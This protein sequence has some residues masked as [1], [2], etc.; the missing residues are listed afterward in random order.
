MHAYTFAVSAHEPLDTYVCV[1]D[2]VSMQWSGG[3][4]FSH[5]VRSPSPY[6]VTYTICLWGLW[7]PMHSTG[8]GCCWCHWPANCRT[9]H[10]DSCAGENTHTHTCTHTHTPVLVPAAG[11]RMETPA[12]VSG[13]GVTHTHTHTHKHTLTRNTH[14]DEHLQRR[15]RRSNSPAGGT[16]RDAASLIRV[17]FVCVKSLSDHVCVCVCVCVCVQKRVAGGAPHRTRADGTGAPRET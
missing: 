5:S 17:W 15:I 10:G 8:C 4:S 6:R 1:C 11:V 14:T 2:P 12:Q 9:L 7:R 16:Y 3:C 13:V